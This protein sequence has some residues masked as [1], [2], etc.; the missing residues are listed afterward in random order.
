MSKLEELIKQLCPNGVEY[1]TLGEIGKVS[2]CKR[3][4]KAETTAEGGVPFYKIGTF[5]KEPD[6]YISYDKYNKYKSKFSYPN[7]GDVLISASGTIGRTVVYNGEPA[8]YQDSNI[9]WLAHDESIVLNTYL[10]YCYELKPWDINNGGTIQ[11]L[12]NDNLNKAKIPVPPMEVQCEI[13]RILDNFTEL[14]AE[15]IAELTARKKQYEYYRDELL[16]FDDSV[17]MVKLDELCNIKGRIGFRGYTRND[18][19]KKGE[20]AISL[21]PANIVNN[22]MSYINCTYLSWYKY[23]ES[24]EI[25][26]N[27]NDV[28][29]CKTGST[30][31]KVAKVCNMP[32]KC[33]INPQLVVLKD[34]KCNNSYLAYI[35]GTNYFKTI[36]HK[37]KGIGSVPTISQKDLSNQLIPLPPLEEQERIVL[38]LDRFDK[39][40]ND[41]SVG[42]PAEIEARKKQYEYY[43]D[44]LLT[45]KPIQ[46]TEKE[47]A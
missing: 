34:I 41:I 25:K 36:V 15:L 1:K 39:L 37:I 45:F 12:Y 10:K 30:V 46:S 21:S 7:K 47:L 9:V 29:F 38:I 31:G 27:E 43:R 19:V 35:L 18:L 14:I 23:D 24:P 13:V 40:C 11:R 33:T 28:I 8:Y 32:E 20:G 5:G 16:T 26:I 42:L 4:M 17:P 2:M 44:K 22:S 3:I 6:A